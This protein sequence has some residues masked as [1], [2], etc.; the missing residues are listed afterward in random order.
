M[1]RDL[2]QNPE[3]RRRL[4][5]SGF[6]YGDLEH[7][8]GYTSKTLTH[9]GFSDQEMRTG[10]YQKRIHPDDLPTYNALWQRVNDGW[11][12]QLYAEYRVADRDGQWHWIETHAVVIRRQGDDSIGEVIGT[13]RNI[14]PRKE[15]ELVLERT[16]RESM[17]RLEVTDALLKAGTLA[18]EH[19]TLVQNLELGLKEMER[20][21]PFDRCDVYTTE[22]GG[23]HHLLI[24]VPDC[25]S[26]SQ[27]PPEPFH[28]EV[29][30]SNYPV[31]QDDGL[32][33][34]GYRSAIG[35]PLVSRGEYVGAVYLWHSDAGFYSGT[36][37]YPLM[38]GA[39]VFAVALSN[40]Q[41]HRRSVA[42]LETDELTGFLTRKSFNRQAR[43]MWHDPQNA[44]SIHTIAMV[45]LDHFK[46]INDTYGHTAGD[47]VIKQV[48][49]LIRQALRAD[50]ILGRYGGEEFVIVLPHTTADSAA[51]IMER[52]RHSCENIDM[53]N[54]TGTVTVSTG[55]AT[56]D[57]E[58]PTEPLNA[59][60]D[61]ADR[62]LYRAKES[63]RNRVEVAPAAPVG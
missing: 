24:T 15:A 47:E 48:A 50:D 21:V 33:D 25:V 22:S 39:T 11:D 29:A 37:L 53:C 41:A 16:V 51:R 58:N 3:L 19:E 23:Q 43:T 44:G 28:E 8:F 26:T 52:I 46:S 38:T 32:D 36:D 61:R 42:E 2:L 6:F 49:Q 1:V 18:T 31:I 57:P 63:G 56:T 60:I 59:V 55:V 12:D 10:T 13:D 54:F 30:R 35:V 5:D 14:S 34:D 62:A 40:Y 20:I 45:D 4:F 7:D 9:L 27:S 17:Q